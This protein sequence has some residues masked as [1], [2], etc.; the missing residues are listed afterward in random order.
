[1]R[2]KSR[3][4]K[5]YQTNKRIVVESEVVEEKQPEILKLPG[6]LP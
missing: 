3:I 1:M 4:R 6:L 5:G 2:R